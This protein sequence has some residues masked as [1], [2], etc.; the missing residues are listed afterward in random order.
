M[1]YCGTVLL[2]YY[3]QVEYTQLPNLTS[4]AIYDGF[5][6]TLISMAED[7][8]DTYVGRREGTLRTF[9]DHIFH[10]QLDG[11]GKATLFV[12]PRYCPIISLGSVDVDSSLLTVTDMRIYHQHVV[13]DDGNFPV[14]RQNVGLHGTMG[15]ANVPDDVSQIALELCSNILLDMVRRRKTPDLFA[16]VMGGGPAPGMSEMGEGF[17]TLF[18]MP[19]VFTPSMKQRLD[20]YKITWIDVA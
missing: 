17:R 6:G 2:Q 19:N 8:I 18:A 1:A 15:Y 16:V 9:N 4:Q 14:G 10:A 5:C 12:P 20:K 3:S 13:Y 11:M 7:T